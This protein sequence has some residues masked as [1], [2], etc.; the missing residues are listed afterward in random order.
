MSHDIYVFGFMA[1]EEY[2]KKN[3]LNEHFS[4]KKFPNIC[5]NIQTLTVKV[6]AA[7]FEK[8][9]LTNEYSKE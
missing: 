6:I 8:L 5:I 3:R 9:K 7:T 2:E 4:W 1:S